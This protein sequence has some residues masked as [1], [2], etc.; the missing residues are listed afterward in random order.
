M[1]EKAIQDYRSDLNTIYH[2]KT[3]EEWE[4]ELNASRDDKDNGRVSN[5][6][7]DVKRMREKYG[8]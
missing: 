3:K 7:E 5:A 1:A 4:R 8:L 6:F 2:P